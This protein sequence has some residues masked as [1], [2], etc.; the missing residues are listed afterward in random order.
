[1]EN[2]RNFIDYPVS[3]THAPHPNAKRHNACGLAATGDDGSTAATAAGDQS[4]KAAVT[5][6]T[7]WNYAKIGFAIVGAVVVVK[8]LYAKIK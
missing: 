4:A 8:Y 3:K 2:F 1:M 5:K 7:L 6:L